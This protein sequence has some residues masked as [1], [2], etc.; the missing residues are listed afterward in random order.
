MKAYLKSIRWVVLIGLAAWLLL[1]TSCSLSGA[2]SPAVVWP[3]GS[4]PPPVAMA[5]AAPT[6]I[7]PAAP[8]LDDDLAL[9]EAADRLVSAIYARVSPA[10]VHI[11]ARVITLDFFWGPLPSEGTGSGFVIDTQGH[12]VTNYHVIENAESIEVTLSDETKLPAQLVGVDPPN[13]LAVLRIALPPEKL[14]PVPLGDGATLRVGQRAIA[15]GNPFGLDRTLTVGVISA[16]GR[17]LQIDNNTVIYNVIQTDAAINPGNSGGPLLNIRGE[18]IGVNTAIRQNAEGIGFAVSVD[19]VRRV[20]PELIRYGRYAHPWLGILGYS[21]T[22]ELAQA[23]NLPVER[24]VLVA[25]LYRNSPADI[26]GIRGA[27]RQ[28]R[29]GNQRILIGGD[30][31]V[32]INGVPIRDWNS[33]QEYLEENTRV[34]QTVTLSILRDGQPLELSVTLAE[35]P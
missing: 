17:P 10:V 15:I 30:V 7:A 20:V 1:G 6:T 3:A 9:V 11:T 27:V 23:L 34:G 31:L 33:L 8:S 26:A 13:D 4:S 21:I 5:T 22:P 35:Q 29:V 32:A 16:L 14:T 18:V 12:I 28:V 19:T 24:G 2:L 25:R